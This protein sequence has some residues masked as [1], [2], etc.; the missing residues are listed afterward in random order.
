M[1]TTQQAEATKRKHQASSEA[2]PAKQRNEA[3]FLLAKKAAAKEPQRT[4]KGKAQKTFSPKKSLVGVSD[5]T[6][7]QKPCVRTSSLFKNNPEIPELHRYVQGHVRSGIGGVKCILP[8]SLSIGTDTW[9]FFI[10]CR[11]VV[12]QVQEKVFTSDAFHELDLHPHLVSISQYLVWLV[13][14]VW[15]ISW[16]CL[17]N[18]SFRKKNQRMVISAPN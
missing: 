10:I 3:S 4:F 8:F 1:G 15:L 12:K 5:G 7:E 2:P 17:G 6:R 11:P 9:V 14:S 16:E 13:F 18:D